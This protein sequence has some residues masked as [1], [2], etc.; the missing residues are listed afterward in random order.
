MANFDGST[1]KAQSVRDANNLLALFQSIYQT[2]KTIQTLMAL[3]QAGTDPTFNGA[4]NSLFTTSERQ[5]LAQMQ[6]QVNSLVVDWEA[7]HSGAITG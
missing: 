3:Y 6:N 5:E 2:G 1:A 4:I 7:N